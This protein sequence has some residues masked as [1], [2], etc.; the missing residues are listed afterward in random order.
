M[1]YKTIGSIN[2]HTGFVNCLEKPYN[3]SK[4][5]GFW[6]VLTC[7]TCFVKCGLCFKHKCM[8]ADIRALF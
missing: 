7:I 5:K 3:L 6:F 2:P 1:F 8:V 4:P